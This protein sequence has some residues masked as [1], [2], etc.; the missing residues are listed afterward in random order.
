MIFLLLTRSIFHMTLETAEAMT[1][2]N[3]VTQDGEDMT[4]PGQKHISTHHANAQ[5][6]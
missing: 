6:L 5:I 3:G 1:H 2:K 4:W